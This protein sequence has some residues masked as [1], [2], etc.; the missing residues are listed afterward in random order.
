MRNLQ[1]EYADK[2]VGYSAVNMVMWNSQ[3]EYADKTVLEPDLNR[4]SRVGIK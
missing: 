4:H 2:T 3:S 1:S